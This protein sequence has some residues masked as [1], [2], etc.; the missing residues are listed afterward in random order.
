[1][2]DAFRNMMRREAR[3]AA[4]GH[5]IIL[6]G[7][8]VASAFIAPRFFPLFDNVLN[9]RSSAAFF[10]AGLIYFMK[11]HTLFGIPA[12]LLLGYLDYRTCLFFRI[13]RMGASASVWAAVVNG[14][15][16]ASVLWLFWA[17][18]I[19]HVQVW[20][21]LNRDADYRPDFSGT[22]TAC[23]SLM[24][25]VMCLTALD[26]FLRHRELSRSNRITDCQR[27]GGVDSGSAGAPTE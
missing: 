19:P 25:A 27:T 11:R 13:R 4:I 6:F 23:G 14:A 12:V 1:M 8:Y 10:A 26:A 17:L 7:L 22:G 20:G 15:V 5:T 9:V 2:D 18:S 3:Q 21:M 16:A 24:A